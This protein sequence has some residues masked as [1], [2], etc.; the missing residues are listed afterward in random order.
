MDKIDRELKGAL[1]E[2]EK[3]E[4]FLSN[5]E[6]LFQEKGV[7]DIS[8][9]AL[10]AEYSGHLKQSASKIESFKLELNKRL[11]I[12]TKE[13][14]VYKQELANMEARLKVGQIS[15]STFFQQSRFPEKKV[16]LLED[17]V[18][19]VNSLINSKHSSDILVSENAGFG[20]F[21]TLARK[22]K[23]QPLVLDNIEKEASSP[24]SPPEPVEIVEKPTIQRDT[25]SITSLSV[26]PDKVLPGSH[27]GV[28]A[29]VANFGT[30]DIAHRAELRINSQL[31]SVIEVKLAPG[32]NEEITFMTIAGSPGEY[33]ITVDSASGILYVLPPSQ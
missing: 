1:L 17:E 20:S 10:K 3:Q 27:V 22:P 26:L 12:K 9:N 2:K 7:N 29:M 4:L 16:S 15:A 23:N 31:E 6:R 24:P 28:V 33:F 30:E 13:L 8:Y 25:T 11:R 19:H 32:Q 18:F 21:F 5:L 14:E